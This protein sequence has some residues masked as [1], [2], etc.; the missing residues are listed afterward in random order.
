MVD[1]KPTLPPPAYPQSH[2]CPQWL[3][4]FLASLVLLILDVV[5]T[6]L[7]YQYHQWAGIGAAIIAVP[8]WIVFM[9]PK[10]GQPSGDAGCLGCTVLFVQIVFL[11]VKSIH[12]SH[13]A[14]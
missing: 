11:V 3:G 5:P 6:V 12:S 7:F 13:V 1:R 4:V 8:L 2:T 10:M 14:G 9:N